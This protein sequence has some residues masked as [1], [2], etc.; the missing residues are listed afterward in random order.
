MTINDIKEK[1]LSD[2]A[3]CIGALRQ[4]FDAGRKALGIG[5][6]ALTAAPW[7]PIAP[8]LHFSLALRYNITYHNNDNVT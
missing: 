5:A 4:D 1:N 3:F 2:L 7:S 8:R 6:T